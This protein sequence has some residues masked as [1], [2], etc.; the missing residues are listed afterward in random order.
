MSKEK[1]IEKILLNQSQRKASGESISRSTL[2]RFLKEYQETIELTEAIN[3]AEITLDVLVRKIYSALQQNP[4]CTEQE[5][6][7]YIVQ[8]Q[9]TILGDTLKQ[10]QHPPLTETALKKMMADY[11]KSIKE[12]AHKSGD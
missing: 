3:S 2:Q 10:A 1:A 12:S 4:D 8:E 9:D 7:H 5:A 6:I 11:K